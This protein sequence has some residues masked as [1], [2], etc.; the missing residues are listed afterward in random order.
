[1]RVCHHLKTDF[2]IHAQGGRRKGK[3]SFVK[4]GRASAWCKSKRRQKAYVGG[5]NFGYSA[6]A[7]RK[8]SLGR[9]LP[10]QCREFAVIPAMEKAGRDSGWEMA[11]RG[12][13]CN[14][15]KPS[16]LRCH[17]H[18]GEMPAPTYVPRRWLADAL[19]EAAAGQS[20]VMAMAKSETPQQRD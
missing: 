16:R 8:I 3:R 20:G 19:Q 14:S 18:S 6:G 5:R 12:L 4:T 9:S 17:H 15:R 2:Y 10:Q 11:S 1:M 7:S 13:E